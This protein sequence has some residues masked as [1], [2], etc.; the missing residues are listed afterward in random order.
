MRFE[1]G[2]VQFVGPRY[3]RRVCWVSELRFD[4]GRGELRFVSG[5]GEMRFGPGRGQSSCVLRDA[6]AFVRSVSWDLDS[7]LPASSAGELTLERCRNSQHSK[8]YMSLSSCRNLEVKMVIKVSYLNYRESSVF[9]GIS[10]HLNILYIHVFYI[11][12]ICNR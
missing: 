9:F 5:R 11:I 8:N 6:R 4:A 1:A 7:G 10:M 12:C 2:R 3:A